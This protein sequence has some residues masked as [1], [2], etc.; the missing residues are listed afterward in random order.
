MDV[1]VDIAENSLGPKSR[2]NNN[3]KSLTIAQQA[4]LLH[5]FGV[6]VVQVNPKPET[7]NPK[8]HTFGVRVATSL[9]RI[10][11]ELEP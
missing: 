8:L 1:A 5:T 2:Q 7:L 10:K 4:L 9:T 11:A 3:P 6:Q